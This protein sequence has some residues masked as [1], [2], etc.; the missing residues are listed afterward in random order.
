VY[1]TSQQNRSAASARLHLDRF[2][3]AADTAVPVQPQNAAGPFWGL[4]FSGSV[5]GRH[6]GRCPQAKRGYLRWPAD[7]LAVDQAK[8]GENLMI[9]LFLSTDGKHTVHVSAQ[10]P[11]EMAKLAP[12]AKALYRRVLE[13]FGTKAQMWDAAIN[14]K[15]NGH[16][17]GFAK[18]NGH[19]RVYQ[20]M[21]P[22]VQE[23]GDAIPLCPM[24][25]RPMAFRQGR[26][27]PFW[28]C[29]TRKPDGRWCQVTMEVTG[30]GNK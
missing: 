15:S 24:H 10:T 14:G 3:P 23:Q 7:A 25:Q 19:A 17:N 4:N 12:V 27:G 29:P 20:R 8:G 22:A 2:G 26:M 13:E 21:E 9:E 30:A 28:S 1:H 11:E 18:S 5:W 16:A 6:G